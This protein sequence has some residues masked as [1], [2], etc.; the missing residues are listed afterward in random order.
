VR[1]TNRGSCIFIKVERPSLE[2]PPTFQRLYMIL[3]VY[4]DGFKVGC[5]PV[6]GVD[7]RF[8]KG[9]YKMQ[10]LTTVERDP[11]DNIYPIT[12]AVVEAECKDS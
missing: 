1:K 11:N 9:Y 6:I 12:M 7:G 10:L 4:N 2:V 3:A 5:R 8:L